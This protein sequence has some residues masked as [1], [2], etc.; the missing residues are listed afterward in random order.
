MCGFFLRLMLTASFVGT[1]ENLTSFV[2]QFLIAE[3]IS[4]VAGYTVKEGS[5]MMRNLFAV[6]DFLNNTIG[7]VKNSLGVS[8]N[9]RQSLLM[10]L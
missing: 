10:S 3:V 6:K 4:V 5:K 7:A 8:H 1:G 9:F 2:T